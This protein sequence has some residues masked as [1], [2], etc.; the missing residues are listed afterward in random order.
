M[1]RNVAAVG[2]AFVAGRS[3]WCGFRKVPGQASAAGQWVDFS[4]AAGNP[5]PQYY[6]S[7]PLAA[8]TLDGFDGIFHGDAKTPATK[9]LV[10]LGLMTPTAAMVGQYQLC[11]YL[12]YYPFIDGD[13]L[14]YQ[15]MTNAVTLPRYANGEGV[16]VMAV[17]SAP[18][19][20]GG[21]F[22]FNYVDEQGVSR[23]SPVINCNVAATSI[24]TVLTSEPGTVAGGQ[25]LL[26]LT[27]GSR[28]VRS[29]TG[30]QMLAASGGLF[31]LVLMYPL[32]QLAIREVNTMVESPLIL[33]K[34]G[35]PAIVD[36][37]YLGLIGQCAGTV[38]AG[39]LVG[40]ATFIWS[41]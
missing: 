26:P 3:H 15:A 38:A 13:S 36:G 27:G 19:T 11:D 35:A 12:L 37:A 4:M 22:T 1:L 28:G 10:Q 41:E 31:A 2:D 33:T 7:T 21:Q 24:A 40:N 8:A 39:L 34:P 5:K 25:F 20:G 16:M 32:H 14:D 18:T 30:V 23:T 17:T 29:I 6:A 9:H